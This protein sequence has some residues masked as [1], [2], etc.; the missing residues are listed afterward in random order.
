MVGL[1]MFDRLLS[2]S[3]PLQDLGSGGP[4]SA[5]GDALTGLETSEGEE[6]AHKNTNLETDDNNVGEGNKEYVQVEAVYT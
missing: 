1:V 5:G 4:Q 6:R 2:R 3:D